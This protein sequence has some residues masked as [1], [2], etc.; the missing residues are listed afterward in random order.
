MPSEDAANITLGI[1]TAVKD[2]QT[3]VSVVAFQGETERLLYSLHIDGVTAGAP[4][5][6]NPVTPSQDL[7][8]LPLNYSYFETTEAFQGNDGTV[9]PVGT[10]LFAG[11]EAV[12]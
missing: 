7:D 12:S 9:I 1:D 3:V 6:V 5:S 8:G 11:S 10:L 2:D 4:V